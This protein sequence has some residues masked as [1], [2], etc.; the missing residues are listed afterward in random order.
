MLT[1]VIVEDRRRREVYLVAA[2][3]GLYVNGIAEP[4][5]SEPARRLWLMGA[6]GLGGPRPGDPASPGELTARVR[7][8]SPCGDRFAVRS[9]IGEPWARPVG[10]FRRLCLLLTS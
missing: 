10:R 4:V 3:R 9:A 2:E 1:C 6:A 8:T 5:Q 7:P